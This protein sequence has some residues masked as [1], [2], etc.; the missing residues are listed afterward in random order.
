MIVQDYNRLL[1][2]VYSELC[3]QKYAFNKVIRTLG[4]GFI[5][6]G[7]FHVRHSR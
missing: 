4:K 3:Q 1:I 7:S 6:V 5:L 2:P